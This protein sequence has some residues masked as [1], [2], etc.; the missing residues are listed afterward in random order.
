MSHHHRIGS[1]LSA[2][3]L[4]LLAACTAEHDR[5]AAQ[6]AL[7]QNT[8]EPGSTISKAHPPYYPNTAGNIVAPPGNPAGNPAG[9]P[10]IVGGNQNQRGG[11][12]EGR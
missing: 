6:N 8:G 3:G 10:P 1:Y 4:V 7:S 11:W 2:A 5:L 9:D 12:P